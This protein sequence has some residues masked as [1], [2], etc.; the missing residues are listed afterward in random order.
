MTVTVLRFKQNTHQIQIGGSTCK[1]PCKRF[2]PQT[3]ASIWQF[4]PTRLLIT[5]HKSN[6]IYL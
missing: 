5:T 6:K 1:N 4:T 2:K 3:A